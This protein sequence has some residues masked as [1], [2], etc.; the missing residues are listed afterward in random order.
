MSFLNS[1]TG[2][3]NFWQINPQLIIPE[4]FNKL[5]ESDKSKNKEESS[6]IMYALCFLIDPSDENR[7][8]NIPEPDRRILIAKDYLKNPKFVWDKDLIEA[9]LKYITT[10]SERSLYSMEKELHERDLFIASID[11]EDEDKWEQKEK[12]LVNTHKLYEQL[13]KIKEM[14]QK[15]EIKTKD[16]GGSKPTGSD[17]GSM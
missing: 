4:E 16:K 7:F 13:N 1:Y 10:Q 12:M 15:E 6:K 11:W 17:T 14:V 5:Y 8:K 2:T 3:G 9:G